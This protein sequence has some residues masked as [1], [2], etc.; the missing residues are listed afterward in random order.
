VLVRDVLKGAVAA[1]ID[2]DADV[3]TERS[4][5]TAVAGPEP[6]PL[7]WLQAGGTALRREPESLRIND[8]SGWSVRLAEPC[9]PKA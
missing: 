7:R 4:H 1:A 3:H 5:R 6:D 2:I 8:R 9:D